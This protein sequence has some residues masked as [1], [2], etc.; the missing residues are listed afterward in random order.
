MAALIISICTATFSVFQWWNSQ[1][2][3]RIKNAIDFSKNYYKETDTATKFALMAAYSGKSVS[4]SEGLLVAQ[5]TDQLE[6]I[7]L[8]TNTN[9]L[10]RNF[11]SQDIQCAM[12]FALGAHSNIRKTMPVLEAIKLS[13]LNKFSPYAQCGIKDAVERQLS[14]PQSN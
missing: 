10:D 14:S 2:E 12:V 13:E 3:D 4:I 9:K 1:Q 7:A 5:F 11:L 8:L 6:Y